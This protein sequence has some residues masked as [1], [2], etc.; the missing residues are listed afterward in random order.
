MKPIS[1]AIFILLLASTLFPLSAF[2]VTIHVP[3]DQSTIQTG[4]DAAMGGD[5]V[6]VSPGTYVE[7]INFLGKAITLQSET[8]AENTVIDGNQNGS[9]VLFDSGETQESVLD[10]FT[11]RNGTGTYLEISGKWFHFGG[12]ILCATSSSPKIMNCSII[13]NHCAIAGGVAFIEASSATITNCEIFNNRAELKNGPGGGIYCYFS[14]PTIT[15]CRIFGNESGHSGGGIYS[16]ESSPTI[17]NCLIVENTAGQPGGGIYINHS[18]S[19]TIT[20]CTISANSAEVGSSG[21]SC[22]ET[23]FVVSVCPKKLIDCNY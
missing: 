1:L 14:S 21:I 5:L 23:S 15:N 3:A 18:S 7:N 8:G 19:T 16:D 10:G 17:A 4:I 11:I 22:Y 9:V 6:L 20:N 13:D 2:A 12:G